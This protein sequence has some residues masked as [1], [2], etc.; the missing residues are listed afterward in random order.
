MLGKLFGS[1]DKEAMVKAKQEYETA[2]NANDDSRETRTMKVRMGLRC[3]A[4]L[5]K[6]FI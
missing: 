3:R 1:A 4:V 6:T 5:D 2:I